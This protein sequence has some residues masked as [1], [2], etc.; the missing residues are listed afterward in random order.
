MLFRSV[1]LRF[2]ASGTLTA[3]STD[4]KGGSKYNF[5]TS[6]LPAGKLT[7]KVGGS[8]QTGG[9]GQIGGSEQT[10]DLKPKEQTGSAQP[11]SNLNS[12]TTRLKQ[13]F[14]SFWKR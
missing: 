2:T 1:N 7:V 4:P 3:L 13:M 12:L 6:S 10:M 11:V 8:G 5:D 14:S 9:S